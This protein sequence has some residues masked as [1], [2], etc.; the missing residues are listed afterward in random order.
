VTGGTDWV[1]QDIVK[2]S[3]VA[4]TDESYIREHYPD[5]C[6]LAFVLECTQGQG[7]AGGAFPE[8]SVAANAFRGKLL[9]LMAVHLLLLAINTI[10]PGL[11]G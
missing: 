4:V 7:R 8:A 1:A 6:S 5:L 9:G 11:R 10:A 2:N 3:L